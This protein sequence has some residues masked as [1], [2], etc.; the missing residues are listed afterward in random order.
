MVM[1]GFPELP[2]L[3]VVPRKQL[4]LGVNLL[5]NLRRCWS[6]ESDSLGIVG[7]PRYGK[8]SGVIIP[9]VLSWAGPVVCVSTG[10]D[11]LRFT[12]DHRR[13]IAAAGGGDVYVYDPLGTQ[14]DVS[15]VRWSPLEGCAD[16]RECYYRVLAMTV[17]VS[18]GL[19]QER[20]WRHGMIVILRA[21]LHA[22]AL[23]R[24]R[25]GQVRQWLRAQDPAEPIRILRTHPDAAVSWADDVEALGHLGR[26]DLGR[27]YALARASLD[28]A[29]DPRAAAATDGDDLDF[30]RFLTSSSTLYVLA[31]SHYR[32]PLAP[33]V[34][35]L[36]ESLTRRAGQLAA[37]T[38][39]RLDPPLLLVYDDFGY[40]PS[41]RT[42]PG[43][44][45]DAGVRG[46][47]TVWAAHS[48]AQL[49]WRYSKDE[50]E[51]LVTTT[52]AK[53]FYGGMSNS[54]DLTEISGWA[55]VIRDSQIAYYSA[56]APAPPV[57]AAPAGLTGDGHTG[58]SRA[59]DGGLNMPILPPEALQHLPPFHA[60]LFY[61]SDTPL[62]VE[63]RPAGFIEAYQRL[64]GFTPGPAP[65]PAPAGL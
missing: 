7:P 39:G 32:D 14:R 60:W 48:L 21:Y 10:A 12:G 46:V 36:T 8:T 51:A 33:T 19:D 23:A 29:A 18:Q 55:G 22:A 61:R 45:P 11:V 16:P 56:G 6:L 43:L 58:L 5:N 49:R 35:C 50:V 26:R 38:G 63:T 44:I 1:V 64:A 52:A 59:S 47:V 40:I 2:P 34:H 41:I 24:A 54:D 27:F 25:L 17:M 62:L 28:I 15:G 13:R 4:Y 3:D 30:D 37:A 9:S 42:L 57:F 20:Y 65:A 31:S 53:L